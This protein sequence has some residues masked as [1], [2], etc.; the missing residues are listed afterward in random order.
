M[1]VTK[2][3]QPPLQGAFNPKISIFMGTGS[4]ALLAHLV[5]I[6]IS[7]QVTEALPR[8]HRRASDAAHGEQEAARDDAVP[9]VLLPTETRL[10]PWTALQL[11][12]QEEKDY[13]C[14]CVY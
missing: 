6:C 2:I 13:V 7:V 12:R 4:S 10:E 1:K 5:G 8:G 14:V 9:V 11:L 3:I